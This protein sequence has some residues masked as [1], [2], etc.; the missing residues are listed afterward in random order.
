MEKNCTSHGDVCQG[1]V[2]KGGDSGP[3]KTGTHAG[4]AAFFT[5]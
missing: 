3:D 1:V 4:Q 5:H 2:E